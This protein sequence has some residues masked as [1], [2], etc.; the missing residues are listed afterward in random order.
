VKGESESIALPPE[1]SFRIRERVI[2]L[3]EVACD[4]TLLER[5]R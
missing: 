5:Q 1:L 2:E 3:D 4:I